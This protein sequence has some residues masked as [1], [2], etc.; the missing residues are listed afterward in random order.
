MIAAPRQPAMLPGRYLQLRRQAS[1]LTIEQVAVRI[2]PRPSRWHETA[3]ALVA[4]EAGD[5]LP[6]GFTALGLAMQLTMA[7]QFDFN[8]WQ[9]L[10]EHAADPDSEL[11]LPRL[12]RSCGCSFFDPCVPD[13]EAGL[14]CAWRGRDEVGDADL[15]T[16]CPLPGQAPPGVAAPAPGIPQ[17]E[18]A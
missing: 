8:A 3:A 1:G 5:P 18:A 14:G 17:M 9:A 11:P 2:S 12:C 7:V 16:A 13:P 10:V 4:L 15:C 6:T